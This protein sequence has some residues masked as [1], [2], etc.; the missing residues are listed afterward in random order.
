MEK[1]E[2]CP[3]SISE[4]R[5]TDSLAD[6]IAGLSQDNSQLVVVSAAERLTLGEL[7]SRV[8]DFAEKL[9]AAG[10]TSGSPVATVVDKSADTFVSMF[11]TWSAGGVYVPINGRY[12]ATELA[13]F[14]AETPVALTIASP[15]ARERLEIH[16]PLVE[17]DMEKRISHVV[18]PA[19]PGHFRYEPDVALALRTSGT[20]GPPKSV[21][22]R[23]SGTIGAIDSSLRKLRRNSS[24]PQS[25]TPRPIRMNMIPTSL[26]LWAGIYNAA[27]AL[28]AGFGVVML[29]KFSVEA[30][31]AA[32][33]E[34]DIKSTVLAPAMITMLADDDSINDLGP[35]NLVR[36][37]TAPLSP[38]IARKFHRKF[39]VFVLNSYG[40]TELG[41]EVVGWTALDVRTFGLTKL[42]AAG[43]AYD[44]VDVRITDIDGDE[45]PHGCYGEIHVNSPFRMRD[46]VASADIDDSRFVD[47]YLRTGDMGMIDSDGFIWIQGR[48]S[49]MINRGGLKIF[50]DEVEE[51]LREHPAVRDAAV[52]GIPD[53]RLG[54]VPHAWIITDDAVVLDELS[55]WCRSKLVPYK[56]PTDFT[57]VEQFP[58]N[59]IGKV[60]R[61]DLI[62]SLT[63]DEDT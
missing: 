1:I 34:F 20:T 51:V 35:L 12:T 62:G 57:L 63:H 61:R 53:R 43:R 21:L 9:R 6:L 7:K 16:T 27:F 5:D 54:E 26:A 29:D 44:D 58:R 25:F 50:P 14:L 23:H 38:E 10:V 15:Q 40:Q 19:A 45:L 18:K 42:G 36:S 30:F 31:V 37:I 56:V 32:V 39:G 46:Y 47:G 24:R 60:L 13:A 55:D 33:H 11:A 22:L 59:E 28:R 17:F 2:V 3:T 41:G 4:Q 52:A 48:V 8:A 49:D